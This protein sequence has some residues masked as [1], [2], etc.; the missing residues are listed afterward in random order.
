M[1]LFYISFL[2]DFSSRKT[3]PE[4]RTKCLQFSPTGNVL[5]FHHFIVYDILTQGGPGQLS[6]LKDY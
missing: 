6:L 4:I 5:L 2:G 1:S 3:H